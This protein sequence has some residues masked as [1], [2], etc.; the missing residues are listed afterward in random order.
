VVSFDLEASPREELLALV[1]SQAQLV[2]WLE[3]QVPVL[4]ARVAQPVLSER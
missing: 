4:L 1:T 2:E 3:G